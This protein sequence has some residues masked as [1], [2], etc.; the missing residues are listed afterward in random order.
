[1]YFIK[2]YLFNQID[3]VIKYRNHDFIN[4]GENLSTLELLVLNFGKNKI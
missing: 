1:M 4:E 3:I 2:V